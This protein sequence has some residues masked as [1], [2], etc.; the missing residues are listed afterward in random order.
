MKLRLSPQI[1]VLTEFDYYINKQAIMV[2]RNNITCL[3]FKN[4]S[5]ESDPQLELSLSSVVN[6]LWALGLGGGLLVQ[7]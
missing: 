5:L 4:N 7:T 6:F 2:N 1:A 3:A